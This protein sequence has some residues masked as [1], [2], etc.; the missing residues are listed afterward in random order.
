MKTAM[1]AS[2]SGV[3]DGTAETPPLLAAWLSKHNV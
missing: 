3:L 2:L 1:Q